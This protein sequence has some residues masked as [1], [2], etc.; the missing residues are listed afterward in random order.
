MNVN[1]YIHAYVCVYVCMCVFVCL[2]VFSC[3]EGVCL[4]LQFQ[5]YMYLLM[6]C[7]WYVCYGIYLYMY[8]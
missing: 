8:T 6:A 2:F 5:A 1:M 3:S 4:K 7:M